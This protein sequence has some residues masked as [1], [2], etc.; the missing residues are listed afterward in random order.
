MQD[1]DHE[2][3][4]RQCNTMLGDW[5]KTA[6]PVKDVCAYVQSV[7]VEKDLS[8][9]NGDEKYVRNEESCKAFSKLRSSIAGL[10]VWRLDSKQDSS[11]K[12]RLRAE[13]D[14][15]F[16][17]SFALCP[18]SPEAIYRY[19]NLLVS[20]GR[21]DDAILIVRTARKVT[22]DQKQVDD[23]L[24]HLLNMRQPKAGAGAF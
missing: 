10:Y 13:A 21:T 14:F 22:P 1:G 6:T 12:A 20:Q 19:C 11:D 3:W 23:L 7:Y 24:E 9:F 4:T 15:A 5:L 16:R 8:H 2:F 17:Q 18:Y